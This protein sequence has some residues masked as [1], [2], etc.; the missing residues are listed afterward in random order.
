MDTHLSQAPA[1]QGG[2]EAP[3][4]EVLWSRLLAAANAHEFAAAWLVLQARMLPP[5]RAIVLILGEPERGPFAPVGVYPAPAPISADL[6][7]AAELALGGRKGVLRERPPVDGEEGVQC[8]ALPIIV[9]ELL[10]GVVA[11]DLAPPFNEGLADIGRRLQWGTAWVES[12]IRRGAFLPDRQLAQILDLVAMTMEAPSLGVALQGIANEMCRL[13]GVEW[14]AFG[15]NGSSSLVEMKA[16]SHGIS[17]ST[18][19]HLVRA[20]SAAMQESVDQREIISVPESSAMV[21]TR[22]HV[23]LGALAGPGQIMSV[24]VAYDGVINGILTLKAGPGRVF[25]DRDR[26]F[27]RLT[28]TVLGPLIEFKRKDDRWIGAKV[29]DSARELIQRLIGPGHLGL[30]AGA[31]LAAAIAGIVSYVSADYRVTAA[32]TLEGTV[33]RVVTAPIQGYIAKASARAGDRVSEGETLARLDDRSL[34]V[35]LARW[36]SERDQ[37]LKEYQRAMAEGDRTRVQVLRAEIDQSQAR[38][39]LIE[40][41]LGRLEIRSPFDGIIV[42]GD[43]S[44]MLGAPVQRGDLLFE[45]APLDDYRVQ[46]RVDERDIADVVIGQ[47]GTLI[48][49]SLPTLSLPFSVVK[50]TPISVAEE[51]RNNFR[52]EALLTEKNPLVRPGMQGYGKIIIGPRK[53]IYIATARFAQWVRLTLW[54]WWP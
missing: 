37:R 42:R 3:P 22:S 29:A 19:A 8:I 4:G 50:L 46:L 25:S 14:V 21:V 45:I 40:E 38:I 39:D 16:L 43:L 18:R 2:T 36:L 32:A 11:V 54:R 13:L 35:E 20:V 10:H 48:L 12:L 24:P 34:K 33:Q 5:L 30:K 15:L 44:Q 23:A 7:T 47:T 31:I 6:S 51:G 41:Q 53:L 52:V 17:L 1:M 27:C 28:S 26:E 49:S 9:D